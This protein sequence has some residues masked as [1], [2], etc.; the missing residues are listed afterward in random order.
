MSNTRALVGRPRARAT[1]PVR[2]GFDVGGRRDSARDALRSRPDL[3]QRQ[4]PSL[5]SAQRRLAEPCRLERNSTRTCRD[6]NRAVRDGQ[7]D[8]S[9]TATGRP[10]GQPQFAGTC[11]PRGRVLPGWELTVDG[12]QRTDL[13]S[14]CHDARGRSGS[15][16]SPVGLYLRAPD[17]QAGP[18]GLDCGPGRLSGVRTGVC[19]LASRSCPGA[20]RVRRARFRDWRWGGASGVFPTASGLAQPEARDPVRGEQ[21]SDA[22]NG[23]RGEVA[24]VMSRTAADD[25][26]GHVNTHRRGA[27]PDVDVRPE[28]PGRSRPLGPYCQTKAS[29][30]TAPDRPIVAGRRGEP[31]SR[32]EAIFAGLPAGRDNEQSRPRRSEGSRGPGVGGDFR[33]PG[34]VR[35][36]A[37][38]AV[39]VR[40][41]ADHLAAI[42]GGELLV[43]LRAGTV[44]I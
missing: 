44:P 18:V 16:P 24:G 11:G 7:G 28:R 36:G 5:R 27:V 17:F 31:Q 22:A 29:P 20:A 25:A 38:T 40:I 42:A 4:R 2:E 26:R 8:L 43:D 33:R 23:F 39:S 21:T 41:G 32:H 3:E 14:Q 9:H 19:T 37:C 6:A 13:S 10:R 1:R 35:R 12:K 34:R 15:R 30:T